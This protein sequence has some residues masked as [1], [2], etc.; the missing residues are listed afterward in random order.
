MNFCSLLE[1]PTKY[2]VEDVTS[3]LTMQITIN[4]I[5]PDSMT[6]RKRLG[7]AKLIIAT[8]NNLNNTS[9]TYNIIGNLTISRN[10]YNLTKRRILYTT[11]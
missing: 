11:K 6:K 1:K 2:S 8:G 9:R 5:H 7:I 3:R 10:K 4:L